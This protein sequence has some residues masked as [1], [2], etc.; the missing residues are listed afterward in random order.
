LNVSICNR[1]Q[2]KALSLEVRRNVLQQIKRTN[3]VSDKEQAEKLS[4]QVNEAVTLLNEYNSRLGTEMEHRKKVSSMIRDF[5]QVQQEL[6]A[7]A[8]QNLEVSGCHV[9]SQAQHWIFRSTKTN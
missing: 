7:Q 1:K 5:L 8:E 6:L 4:E 9:T 2:T 3:I